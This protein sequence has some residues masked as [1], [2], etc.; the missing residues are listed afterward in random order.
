VPAPRFTEDDRPAD[1]LNGTGRWLA[2]ELGWRWV[3]SRRTAEARDGPLVLRL[4]LQSS[5]WSRAGVATWVSARVSVLDDDLRAWRVTRPDET[6]FPAGRVLP[7]ACNTMLSSVE[8][9]LLSLECS[10]LPQPPPAPRTIST[11]AFAAR[12]RER[13]LP[14]LG[15]FGSSR[16]LASQMP[17]S[18]LMTIDS[19]TIEQALARHDRESAAALIGR[20]MERP[21]RGHQTWRDR[22]GGFRHGWESAPGE[23]RPPPLGTP[24]LGWLARI[25]NLPGPAAFREPPSQS[26]PGPTP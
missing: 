26:T 2:A 18:W 22:I 9:A 23:D 16:L 24:A 19:G 20:H 14:V 3:K 25:H 5:K 15:L 4:I 10:G 12:F 11:R 8:P 21:L 6:V 7:F 1:I 13:V 17:D